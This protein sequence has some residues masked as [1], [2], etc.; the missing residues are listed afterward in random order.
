MEGREGV[1]VLSA[2]AGMFAS[3]VGLSAAWCGVRGCQA[4]SWQEVEERKTQDTNKLID[5]KPHLALGL[6]RLL[7]PRLSLSMTHKSGV[8]RREERSGEKIGTWT[9]GS[10]GLDF[11]A[12]LSGS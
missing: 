9:W 4:Q 7:A 1:V 6:V 8:E 5:P 12:G 3:I 2:G 10:T 11:I